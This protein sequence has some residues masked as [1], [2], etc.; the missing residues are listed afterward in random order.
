MPVHYAP[1]KQHAVLHPTAYAIDCHYPSVRSVQDS[2]VGTSSKA[3]HGRHVVDVDLRAPPRGIVRDLVRCS[4]ACTVRVLG[5]GGA[6]R[7]QPQPSSQL[8]FLFFLHHGSLSGMG[9]G[10]SSLCQ[11]AVGGKVGHSTGHPSAYAI[12]HRNPSVRSVQ[13]STVGTS[14]KAPHGRH[15]VGVDPR[16]PPRRI[17]RDLVRCSHACTVR[18]L[19]G[20]GGAERTQLQ[21]SSQLPFL[22]SR[23]H[24]LIFTVG[25]GEGDSSGSG[26][27]EMD[28]MMISEFGAGVVGVAVGVAVGIAVGIAVG[29]VVG[30][31]VGYVHGKQYRVVV[32]GMVVVGMGVGTA[33]GSAA[34]SLSAW[35]SARQSARPSAWSSARLSARQSA[36][37]STWLSV[38]LSARQSAAWSSSAWPSAR[39]SARLSARPLARPLAR[40]SAA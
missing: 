15:V 12:D 24:G 22:S 20:G 11:A 31:A 9:G 27:S 25:A 16:A 33:V 21:S 23:H 14:S 32:G 30:T 2:T 34:W 29:T 36:R 39:P 8:P 38:R 17:A 4:H 7:T 13:D 40:L 26:S 6:E 19:G 5:G 28:E 18:V 10:S 3:P 37:P 1:C 35:A